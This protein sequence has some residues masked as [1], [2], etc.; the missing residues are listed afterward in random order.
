[1][2]K[3]TVTLFALFAVG[4]LWTSEAHSASLLGAGS[5][6][7]RMSATLSVCRL[8]VLQ[9]N[10]G[11]L[12]VESYERL[13]S[14]SRELDNLVD[15]HAKNKGLALGYLQ[16][17][18]LIAESE[19]LFFE[20]DS[21]IGRFSRS[22]TATRDRLYSALLTLM[23]NQIRSFLGMLRSQETWR[24]SVQFGLGIVQTSKKGF[25]P[26]LKT[27]FDLELDLGSQFESFVS[28][29]VMSL[30]QE[31][32]G[33]EPISKSVPLLPSPRAAW[34]RFK[35]FRNLSL[36]AGIF[37]DE[38]NITAP[39]TWPFYSL[40]SSILLFETQPFSID[41]LI[42]HDMW[43]HSGALLNERRAL[44]IERNL[45]QIHA[46]YAVPMSAFQATL[47]LNTRLHWYTDKDHLLSSLW[48][49]RMG[50]PAPSVADPS[51][52]YRIVQGEVRLQIDSRERL[53]THFSLQR[54]RNVLAKENSTGWY[55]ET[56]TSWTEKTTQ[57]KAR[58]FRH[59]A[60]CASIPPVQ[61]RS[62]L[63]PGWALTGFSATASYFPKVH[64][65]FSLEFVTIPSRRALSG[66]SC[67]PL[68]QETQALRKYELLFSY[69]HEILSDGSI[70]F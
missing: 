15:Q 43:G 10:A 35:K 68:P 26:V 8:I 29:S 69:F 52:S 50:D 41:F 21:L 6:P 53:K 59:V 16:K 51:L 28:L 65:S 11:G 46:E 12:N 23:K 54:W 63:V 36:K 25:V 9:V 61:Q 20:L 58:M 39:E 33:L 62:H 60:S 4:L 5:F 3:L 40:H 1:M 38:G 42:R 13:E 70:L 17:E 67:L 37:P 44:L 32:R 49:G 19:K 18:E 30:T 66:S 31:E 64:D 14:C 27:S 7:N 34:I 55:W 56:S 57:W 45:S 24:G 2:G 22:E 48:L 47:D